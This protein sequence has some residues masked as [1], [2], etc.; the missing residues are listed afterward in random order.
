MKR[1]VRTE[2]EVKAFTQVFQ[3]GYEN[4]VKGDVY[5]VVPSRCLDLHRKGWAADSLPLDGSDIDDH[6]SDD[7]CEDGSENAEPVRSLFCIGQIN[8]EG[9]MLIVRAGL[10]FP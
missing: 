10:V 1:L 7:M 2:K 5:M 3:Q 4:D 8:I 9:S 6:G